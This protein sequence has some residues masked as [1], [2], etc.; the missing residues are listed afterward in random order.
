M[1]KSIKYVLKGIK[2]VDV[3]V[4]L[5]FVAVMM[6]LMKSMDVIEGLCS[7][8]PEVA[9]LR[10]DVRTNMAAICNDL[11][12]QG[13]P[14]TN[15]MN[16]ANSRGKSWEGMN[17]CVDQVDIGPV[18]RTEQIDLTRRIVSPVDQ[19]WP[20]SFT[21][22]GSSNT[23][24]N[25]RYIKLKGL[26]AQ[27]PA[28]SWEWTDPPPPP[29]S[30]EYDIMF[31][32]HTYPDG[33]RGLQS[34]GA[35][36]PPRQTGSNR[37]NEYNDLPGFKGAPVYV[38]TRTTSPTTPL[39]TRANYPCSEATGGCREYG[40]TIWPILDQINEQWSYPNNWRGMVNYQEITGILYL[41]NDIDSKKDIKGFQWRATWDLTFIGKMLNKLHFK[42]SAGSPGE[43]QL[44][45][46]IDEWIDGDVEDQNPDIAGIQDQDCIVKYEYSGLGNCY[47]RGKTSQ[48]HFTNQWQYLQGEPVPP[49]TQVEFDAM[50][51]RS[52]HLIMPDEVPFADITITRG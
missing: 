41:H 30:I 2:F 17:M 45:T 44:Y 4:V 23:T 50:K 37:F 40:H 11:P 33:V 20:E 35:N 7:V 28:N 46:H 29:E 36:H 49:E 38:R 13:V 21:I 27:G 39:N 18:P 51:W 5:I 6:C 52:N 14:C 15:P 42:Y 47:A 26:A 43:L 19:N 10:P 34:R 8:N 31:G 22:T 3:V 48:L 1:A 25:G 24:A 32:G 16:D 9:L 12:N